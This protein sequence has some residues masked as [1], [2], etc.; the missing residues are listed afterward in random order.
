M[1][2]FQAIVHRDSQKQADRIIAAVARG[3]TAPAC[4]ELICLHKHG[5]LVIMMV[6]K[7]S[8]KLSNGNFLFVLHD[9]TDAADLREMTKQRDI[10]SALAQRFRRGCHFLS[11]EIRNKLFP[12]SLILDVLKNT[13]IEMKPVEWEDRV[14][15]I[16]SILAANAVVTKI[17]NRVL[18]IAKWQANQF[19]TEMHWFL[20]H[21]TV[22]DAC[23]RYGMA[24]VRRKENTRVVF[25]L[26]ADGIDSGIQIKT[27]STVLSQIIDNLVSNAS[28]FEAITGL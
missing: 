18:D 26:N 5:R 14:G 28:K 24:C 16:N 27:D 22:F 10:Q 12:Q 8:R 4:T 13:V 7:T 20:P 23:R 25:T 15:D 17:L 1:N 19:P 3:E 11:H 2:I 6:D 21:E 9:A